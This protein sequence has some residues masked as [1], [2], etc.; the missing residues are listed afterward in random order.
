MDSLR[1]KIT[2]N[3]GRHGIAVEKLADIAKEA[4]RFLECFSADMQLGKGDWI[5]EKFRNGSVIFDL[6][7]AGE[8]ENAALQTSVKALKHM[9]DPKTKVED[10]GFGLS[11][12]TF[13]QFARMA[14]PIETDDAIGIGIYNSRPRPKNYTLSKQ[15]AIQIEK[16]IMQ[17]VEQYGSVQ[18]TITALFKGEK[19]TLWIVEK[20]TNR[21]IVCTYAPH[22][23]KKI[24]TLLEDRDS[25]VN[26]E[27]W[28]T[29]I[30]GEIEKLAIKTIDILEAYRDGDLEKLFGSDPDFTGDLTTEEYIDEIRRET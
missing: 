2:L 3:K 1:I 22:L 11:K 13:L 15:R 25:L 14:S 29:I 28:M 19:S 8:A 6:V 21:R 30:N 23:Y 9:A 16:Q 20:L 24:Y 26:A 18:G 27:G 10:L 7:Y 17:R 12:T 5:A 4:E